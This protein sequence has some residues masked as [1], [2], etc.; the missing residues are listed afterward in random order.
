MWWYHPKPLH[1]SHRSCDQ[2][3][4]SCAG[5]IPTVQH[6]EIPR[7]MHSRSPYQIPKLNFDFLD[8]Y[9]D[10]S[11]LSECSPPHITRCWWTIRKPI[12]QYPVERVK[13]CSRWS[14]K[15]KSC[16]SRWLS[17]LMKIFLQWAL[18]TDTHLALTASLINDIYRNDVDTLWLL[19]SRF[20][21]SITL[22]KYSSNHGDKL[23]TY[24]I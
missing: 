16:S 15:M 22:W 4:G 18:P 20:S 17:R 19:P 13:G 9:L 5:R 14:R 3:R 6:A 24:M 7:K 12:S 2:S 23:N 8:Q 11:H 1:R 21:S 10:L